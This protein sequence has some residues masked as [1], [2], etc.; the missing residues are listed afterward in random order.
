MRIAVLQDHQRAAEEIALDRLPGSAL[1]P[2]PGILR[3][4]YQPVRLDRAAVGQQIGIGG[5]GAI[6]DPDT[7]QKSDPAARSVNWPSGPIRR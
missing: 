5:A 4:G 6:D 1:P 3:E 2:L 7:A